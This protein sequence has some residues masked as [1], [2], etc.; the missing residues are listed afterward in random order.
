MTLR[1]RFEIVPYGDE[2]QSYRINTIKVNN[3]GVVEN[4]GFGNQICS[5]EYF[6]YQEDILGD[7]TE[8]TNGCISRHN[9]KD[10]AIELVKK[11][12]NQITGG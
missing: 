3:I 7:T 4:L 6:L 1:V 11:I 2:S 12:L 10:G 9:R 5:Y 8:I